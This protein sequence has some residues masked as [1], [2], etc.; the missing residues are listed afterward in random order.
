MATHR[1]S[2]SGRFIDTEG[3]AGV[4]KFWYVPGVVDPP[5]G[6]FDSLAGAFAAAV[7]LPVPTDVCILYKTDPLP[8]GSDAP[9]PPIVFPDS[10]VDGEDKVF[11]SFVPESGNTVAAG[12]SSVLV[13]IPDNFEFLNLRGCRFP[14]QYTDS[15][16]VGVAFANG[17]VQFTATGAGPN[18]CVFHQ[19]TPVLAATGSSL[20]NTNV[21]KYLGGGQ[22]ANGSA[23]GRTLISSTVPNPQEKPQAFLFDEAWVWA[24]EPTLHVVKDVLLFLGDTTAI[25]VPV[26]AVLSDA[27]APAVMQ[28]HYLGGS[29]A[30]VSSHFDPAVDFSNWPGSIAVI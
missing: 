14:S 4:G 5:P 1:L 28:I 19:T 8:V 20:P 29:T 12:G 18:A 6:V 16:N 25:A 30:A 7:A 17:L 27:G 3:A 26:N 21:R 22:L 23:S 13:P 9:N 2:P 10:V 24:L 11:L 15:D